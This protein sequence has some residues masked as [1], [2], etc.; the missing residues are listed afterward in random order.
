MLIGHDVADDARG[1]LEL[2]KL[3]ARLGVDRLEIPFERAVEH[4]VPG[5]RQGARPDRELFR[6]R[7]LD[8]TLGVVPGDEVAHAAM[9]VRRRIHRQRGADIGLAG[10]VGDAERLVVHAD[11]VGRH[12]HQVGLGAERRRLL[13]LGPQ[14]RRAD[15]GGVGVLAVLFGRILRHDLRTAILVAGRVHDDFGRPVHGRV[16]LLGHQQLAR[17]AVQRIA[18]AV[19]VEVGQQLARRAV[20]VLVGQDHLVDAVEVPFVMGRHLIDPLGHPGIGVAG[21]DGH[22][23]LVVA[24]TLRRVPGGGVAGAVIDQVQVRVIREPAPDRA[25]AD[26]PLVAFPGLERAVGT[27]RLAQRS[28][29]FRVDQHLGVGTGGIALPRDR[30]V[31]DVQRRHPAADAVF[32][33][34]HADHQ[35]VLDRHGGRGQRFADRRVADLGRPFRLA[36]L[37]VQGHHGGVGLRQEHHPVGVAETAVDGVAA[38]HRDHV[39]VLLRLIAP[40]DLA[41]VVQV[42]RKDVV[43][44]RRVDIHDVADHQRRAFVAAQHAGREG[45][46]DAQVAHVVAVDLVQR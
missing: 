40:Q 28:G 17:L 2:V 15:A 37:G 41:V 18:E 6:H 39:R 4:H 32:A 36:G 29:L 43:R 30:A 27:D 31:L 19:A 25:A 13:V 46:R 22:R 8:L 26:L 10:G 3:L 23:P 20:E 21:K 34:G 1:R 44:E 9:A 5:R 11:V 14:R 16:E 45:P 24:R 35:L 12:V 38:H 33:A 42:Q 7:P